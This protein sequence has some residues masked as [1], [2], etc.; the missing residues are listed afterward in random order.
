MTDLRLLLSVT[1]EVN[2][3]PTRRLIGL[4]LTPHEAQGSVKLRMNG[5]LTTLIEGPLRR[6]HE[7]QS[8]IA[9]GSHYAPAQEY[10]DVDT[11]RF[12]LHIEGMTRTLKPTPKKTVDELG[13]ETIVFVQRRPRR[14]GQ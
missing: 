9:F 14:F 12:G 1:R 2:G 4:A 3:K 13:S 8:L 6:L 10:K 5:G 7:D 11:P